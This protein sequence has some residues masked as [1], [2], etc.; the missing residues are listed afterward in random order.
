MTIGPAESS[1][2]PLLY[3]DPGVSV[4]RADGNRVSF[5]PGMVLLQG[6]T[7]S[8]REGQAV[9]D[10]D[11]GHI[12]ALQAN[13]HIQ[14]GSIRLFFGEVFARIETL[15]QRGGARVETN[16]LTASV[17]GTEY[18]VKRSASN[19]AT[20][21]GTSSVIVRRGSVRCDPV[22]EATWR[23]ITL[24]PDEQFEVYGWRSTPVVR[25]IDA[26]AQTRWADR[27][28]ERLLQPRS[29]APSV[30]IHMPI[31]GTSSGSYDKPEPKYD[32]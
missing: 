21:T 10:F 1:G 22:E 8:T 32:Y 5:E 26:Y 29:N 31:G 13:T 17:D 25:R 27:A 19:D 3:A 12:V 20:D 6:D 14:L 30:G 7:I 18:S 24:R 9:I 11:D 23:P 28:I 4:L 16:E 15:V 2:L